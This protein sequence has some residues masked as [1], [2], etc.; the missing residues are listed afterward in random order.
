MNDN[1]QP[2]K[3][4][5]LIGKAPSNRTALSNRTAHSNVRLPSASVLFTESNSAHGTSRSFSS[6]LSSH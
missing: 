6:K 2:L 3:K 5:I 4:R 1:N